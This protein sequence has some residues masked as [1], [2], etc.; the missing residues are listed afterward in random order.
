MK[1]F[2]VL[3]CNVES[4]D[5]FSLTSWL[6][7]WHL[8]FASPL[9]CQKNNVV[10]FSTLNEFDFPPNSLLMIHEDEHLLCEKYILDPQ[11]ER[12]FSLKW[13]PMIHKHFTQIESNNCIHTYHRYHTSEHAY[14][15]LLKQVLS[16]GE[17]RKDRTGV[18]TLSVFGPQIEF[19]LQQGFPLLTTKRV[20]FAHIAHEV[21]W[22]ISGSTTT[23]YLEKHSVHVWNANTSRS[24]LDQRGLQ[25]YDIGETGPLYGFQWRHFGGDFRNVNLSPGVDQLQ[26]MLNLLRTNPT[27]RR[28]F[29]SAWNAMDLDKMCLEPCHVSFQLYVRSDK[30]LDGKLYMRS[31]DLFLGAPWNI[32]AYSLLIHMFAHL[33]GYVPGKL[34]YSL[35]DAHI[36][37]NHLEQVK[38]QLQRCMRPL[39]SMSIESSIPITKWEDF[40]IEHFRLDNYHPHLAIRAPMAV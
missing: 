9:F 4:L 26:N 21:L 24:F 7:S 10:Q 22:Y 17:S 18:G 16:E 36:Y 5:D 23:E 1:F 6:E 31:N 19:D 20:N 28:I 12:V 38:L 29:M 34:V 3:V 2:S 35:G 40:S 39:P 37:S 13:N 32:A 30:Y 25:S 15:Q 33:S 11:C 8:C 27:S 14:L